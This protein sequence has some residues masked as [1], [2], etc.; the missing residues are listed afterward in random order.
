MSSIRKVLIVDDE[1]TIL[2]L[3]EQILIRLDEP[4]LTVLKARTGR[5]ALTIITQEHPDLVF[6]DVMMPEMDGFKVCAHVKQ[7]L[8]WQKPYIVL[9]TAKGQNSEKQYGL[10]VGANLYMTKPFRP[11]DVLATAQAVLSLS[12]PD[13]S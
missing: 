1:P 11:K 8:K 5:E 7:T 2:I 10:Q 9:L 12:S 3:L 13:P 6:L 4:T